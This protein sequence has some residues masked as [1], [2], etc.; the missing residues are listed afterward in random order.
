M[1]ACA[2][3]DG[4]K[5]AAIT[6][7][8]VATTAAAPSTAPSSTD[9][10]S[11]APSST[12]AAPLDDDPAADAPFVEGCDRSTI[13]EESGPL[14]V[15]YGV[16]D[17][18]LDDTPCFGEASSVVE[19]A[20]FD[21]AIVTPPSLIS[22]V[23]IV[24]GFD[25][26]DS[27]TLAFA[28]PVANDSDDHLIAIGMFSASDD[29]DELRLTM[30]HEL[31]HVFTQTPDQIEVARFGSECDTFFNG[32]G[33]FQPDAYMT[34]WIDQFWSPAEIDSLPSGFGVDITG[35]EER[36]DVDPGYP[37]SYA[38]SHPEEDFAESFSAYVFDVDLP[39]AFAEREAFF[40]A[41]PEFAAMRRSVQRTGL[42]A[43]PGNFDECG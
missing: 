6:T 30:A 39:P 17:G 25:D 35:G 40:D 2:S 1:A 3:D 18:R 28:G 10:S 11:T 42:P 26:R 24:A 22:G 8:P 36:C 38:A 41:Y 29:P 14:A 37:G 27:D 7:V 12:T 23:T 21:L 34:A 9:P 32:F 33:C 4:G 5:S 31:A 13:G 16:T 19:S 15:A 43:P 20:W